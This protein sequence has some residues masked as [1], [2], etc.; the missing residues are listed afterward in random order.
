MDRTSFETINNRR[1]GLTFERSGHSQNNDLR[2]HIPTPAS[3][4]MASRNL[5]SA[6]WRGL[7]SGIDGSAFAAP[8]TPRAFLNP[9]AL[10]SPT[11]YGGYGGPPGP[12]G[13]GTDDLSGLSRGVEQVQLGNDEMDNVYGYCFDRGNGQ[14]TRLIP[15][16]MLPPLKDIPALQQGCD[17]MKVLPVPRGLAPNGR[18]SNSERVELQ[19]R[20]SWS[21]SERR[22]FVLIHNIAA[23]GSSW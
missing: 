23:S 12:N 10:A 11:R 8:P 16:D 21:W 5:T 22:L 14:Y 15:A 18:S 2:D 4:H 7:G 19:V 9:L 13:V 6:N 1:N 17:R 20:R 3:R